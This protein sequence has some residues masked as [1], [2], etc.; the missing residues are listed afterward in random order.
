MRLE[1]GEG[2]PQGR[3]RWL[4]ET[5]KVGEKDVADGSGGIRGSK[6]Q[7]WACEWKLRKKAGCPIRRDE[8]EERSHSGGLLCPWGAMR[9][10]L[11][12]FISAA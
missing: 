9:K 10:A 7:S 12:P 11:P 3:Q 5:D 4:Q 1:G 6:G 8:R 2:W